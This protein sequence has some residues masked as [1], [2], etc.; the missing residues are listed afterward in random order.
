MKK[1][2]VT[3]LKTN[4]N[5][6]V[7][8]RLELPEVAMAIQNG[9]AKQEVLRIRELYHLM[10]PRRLE[11]GQMVT[12]FKPGIRLPRI[13]FAAEFENRNKDRRM[14]SY[15]GLV[16]LE[17]NGLETYEKAIALKKQAV[18]MPETLMAFFGG[19]GMSVKIVCR[20]EMFKD[21]PPQTPPL[22]RE[23]NAQNIFMSFFSLSHDLRV[24][25][26]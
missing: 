25:Q 8:N 12:N 6:E 14:V 18:R 22:E 21:T 11:D 5:K 4:K 10:K 3:L 7:I 17:L 1:I 16:V 9:V 26:C 19:S 13:C 2:N 24:K 23:G 20:G 15:N